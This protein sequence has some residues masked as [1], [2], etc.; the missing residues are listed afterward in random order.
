MGAMQLDQLR[1]SV[2]GAIVQPGDAGYD[3][4][5]KVYNAMIDKR[6]RSSSVALTWRT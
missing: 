3:A 4:A 6:P 5:R 1:S 2:R